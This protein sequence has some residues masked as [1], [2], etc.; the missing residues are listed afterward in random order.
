MVFQLSSARE[1]Q[2]HDYELEDLLLNYVLQKSS[3]CDREL[4][5]I[6]LGVSGRGNR[7]TKELCR[8]TGWWPWWGQVLRP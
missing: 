2:S 7:T 3:V 8:P 1:I 6:G 4:L 5:G